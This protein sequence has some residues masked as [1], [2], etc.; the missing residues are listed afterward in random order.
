MKLDS[1]TP[2]SN[3]ITY[4]WNPKKKDAMNFF[5]EQI[6]THRLRKTYGFQIRHVGGGGMHWGQKWYKIGL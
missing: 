6:M 2:T 3:A 4:M 5:A 1:E